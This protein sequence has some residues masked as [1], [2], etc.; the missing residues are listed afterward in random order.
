MICQNTLVLKGWRKP[1]AK[2]QGVKWEMRDQEN[3][4]AFNPVVDS[5]VSAIC[6]S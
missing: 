3:T 1:Y 5:S 2:T 6:R 4:A